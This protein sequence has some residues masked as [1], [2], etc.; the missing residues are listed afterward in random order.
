MTEKEVGLVYP[1][2]RVDDDRKIQQNAGT[3]SVP[4]LYINILKNLHV[5][6]K[7]YAR[8]PLQ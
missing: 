3:V 6:I 8:N 7:I 4:L 5:V 1:L 2:D